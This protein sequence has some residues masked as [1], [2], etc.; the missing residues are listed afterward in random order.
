M[1]SVEYGAPFVPIGESTARLLTPIGLTGVAL[2]GIAAMIAMF[3]A[4]AL[5]ARADLPGAVLIGGALGCVILTFAAAEPEKEVVGPLG[6]A[7][8]PIALLLAVGY[9][10]HQRTATSPVVPRETF[11][12]RTTVALLVSFFVGVALVAVVVDIPVLARLAY[13]DS[14]VEAALVLLRFLIAVPI[15]AIAGG[16]LLRRLGDG[17][18]AA[19]GLGIAAVALIPMATWG[20]GALAEVSSYVVLVALGL[21]IGLTLAPINNAVLARTASALHGTA[22]ALVVVA[23][24]V[25][26][27]VGLALLTGIGLHAYYREVAGLTEPTDADALI[28]AGLVQVHAVFIG[29]AVAAAI[30][31]VLALGMGLRRDPTAGSQAA[32]RT[33]TVISSPL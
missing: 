27:V 31:A 20:R 18:V 21:G 7:L 28:G 24:M 30:G 16:F 12:V 10:L 32:D 6:Y 2:L 19:V 14:Q 3:R 17:M 5:L 11:S 22:S 13:T 29:A 33:S 1:T 26:M 8:L 25:G 23:R 9:V 15:G 4:R